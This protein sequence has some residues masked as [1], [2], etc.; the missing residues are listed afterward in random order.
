[1]NYKKNQIFLSK[2]SKS[3]T[4]PCFLK[5]YVGFLYVQVFCYK[6]IYFMKIVV[7][8][9]LVIFTFQNTFSQVQ[10]YGEGEVVADF[11]VTDVHGVEHNLYTYTAAG[12]YVF[13]DFFYADCGGCQVL[14]PVFNELY[15]KYGCNE[16]DIVCLSINRGVDN[17]EA[18]LAFETEYGG[19]FHHAPAI[20]RN[21]GAIDVN[22][23]LNPYAYP[24][25]CII[26]P[27]NTLFED[28]ITPNSTVS[29]IEA[30]FP[31]DFE[32]EIMSCTIGTA[33]VI[34]ENTF[35]I[36]PNPNNTSSLTITLKNLDA[37]NVFIYDLLGNLVYMNTIESELSTHDHKLVTGTYFVSVVSGT[38]IQTKKLIVLN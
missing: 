16:G 12:K 10:N 25:V 17:D 24:T 15:D 4:Q 28:R 37:A 34:I 13:I 23:D 35:D 27:D 11:T 14:T 3:T 22:E 36:Y 1:M 19:A 6:Q 18:V 5:L 31:D 21:G 8:L 20:S 38:S 2:Q 32:P 9:I 7:I 30:S 33:N 26:A 29:E